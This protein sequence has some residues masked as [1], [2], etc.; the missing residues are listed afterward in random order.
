MPTVPSPK[1]AP[2]THDFVTLEIGQAA[3]PIKADA[4]FETHDPS[5]L[6]DLMAMGASVADSQ[7]PL[8]LRVP[9]S[10]PK[11]YAGIVDWFEQRRLPKELSNNT[12]SLIA[13]EADFLCMDRL[14]LEASTLY[15]LRAQLERLPNRSD[16]RAVATAKYADTLDELGDLGGG[17]EWFRQ[18]QK[19]MPS[20]SPCL[21]SYYEDQLR[22]NPEQ[23]RNYLRLASLGFSPLTHE[24]V[25]EEPSAVFLDLYK[26]LLRRPDDA[27]ALNYMTGLLRSALPM[28][29]QV[30]TYTILALGNALKANPHSTTAQVS[31]LLLCDLLPRRE[32]LIRKLEG[33][34]E[35]ESGHLPDAFER[36]HAA[37]APATRSHPLA[38][39]AL[40]EHCYNTQ[41][42]SRPTS[43]VALLQAAE[44]YLETQARAGESSDNFAMRDVATVIRRTVIKALC[45]GHQLPRGELAR[46][47]HFCMRSAQDKGLEFSTQKFM[48]LVAGAYPIIHAIGQNP[49]FSRVERRLI[50]TE[51]QLRSGKATQTPSEMVDAAR[52]SESDVGIIVSYLTALCIV[53]RSAESERHLFA[54]LLVHL[55]RSPGSMSMAYYLHGISAPSLNSIVSTIESQPTGSLACYLL[56]QHASRWPTEFEA[57]CSRRREETDARLLINPRD[58]AALREGAWW[59]Y[60]SGQ[61]EEAFGL[62]NQEA[63]L[64]SDRMCARPI[65]ALCLKALGH[66]ARARDYLSLHQDYLEASLVHEESLNRHVMHL[67]LEELLPTREALYSIVDSA[68]T[69]NDEHNLLEQ[70]LF[71]AHAKLLRR[72]LFAGDDASSAT[73]V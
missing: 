39:L 37:V 2:Y 21:V 67:C 33:S 16:E 52:R 72:R 29:D 61:Y 48:L 57:Y 6:H 27:I 43:F 34:D 11:P 13:E 49:S 41:S 24:F 19:E 31:C 42:D 30:A 23:G 18:A 26:A 17:A 50:R 63:D 38:Q 53:N 60:W 69:Y 70:E 54:P 44:N 66:T 32:T 73:G 45:D 40:A 14:G 71:L 3:F 1:S 15:P 51:L 64:Y 59:S 55:A 58:V 35:A 4:F 8:V 9:R 25:D 65:R 5:I 12:L 36:M 22:Q 28:T 46:A 20:G 62:I 10:D 56:C 7:A 68:L 47:S